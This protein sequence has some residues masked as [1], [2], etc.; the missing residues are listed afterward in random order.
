MDRA[1]G[2]DEE[3]II[4]YI[5]KNN[6]FLPKTSHKIIFTEDNTD[7][8]SEFNPPLNPKSENSWLCYAFEPIMKYWV[9]IF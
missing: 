9:Y 8:A 5:V 2:K 7:F 6:P 4:H 1:R 3:R